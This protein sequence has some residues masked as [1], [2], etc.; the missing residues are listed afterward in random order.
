MTNGIFDPQAAGA[1][2]HLIT[3]TTPN[4][5]KE[6][7]LQ[8]EVITPVSTLLTNTNQTICSEGNATI[9]IQADSQ[10]TYTW[11]FKSLTGSNFVELQN[12]TQNTLQTSLAGYYY[13]QVSKGGC[14]LN[15]S[16]SSINLEPSPI[17][18]GPQEIICTPTGSTLLKATPTG[19]TWSGAGV[20]SA[21]GVFS[22][23]SLSSGKHAVLYTYVSPLGC[24][25]LG[26]DT[27]LIDAIPTA[28]LIS[29]NN[30][31]C[32]DHTFRLEV[33]PINN[34][35]TV[36]WYYKTTAQS[37]ATLI[38]AQNVTERSVSS[39]GLY[40]CEISNTN[41]TVNTNTVAIDQLPKLSLQLIAQDTVL[42]MET[43]TALSVSASRSDA[44]LTWFFAEEGSSDFQPIS[45]S[46]TLNAVQD[47]L[48]KVSGQIGICTTET[49]PAHIHF[50]PPDSIE[51]P[52]VFTPNGDVFNPK[53]VLTTNVEHYRF[54]IF[55]RWGERVY[56]VND[57]GT[58]DGNN[59]SPGTYFWAINYFN[60]RNEEKSARGWVQLVR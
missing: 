46:Q 10:S 32:V 44:T 4:C 38:D 26:K 16:I 22:A 55:N 31:Y 45:V 21:L 8:L 37:T 56:Q 25:H 14:S 3:Y 34:D 36:R 49:K 1:G 52:N 30:D 29:E 23:N 48:Y 59:Q 12:Q 24:T 13:A 17:T 20:N 54:S 11:Y 39:T 40:Y 50:L 41:C 57:S 15:S 60:C 53:F 47:G 19:G 27:V 33:A 28:T 5:T 35:L 18:I 9:K 51:A 58:W 42:C 6:G 43:E 2:T 7:K